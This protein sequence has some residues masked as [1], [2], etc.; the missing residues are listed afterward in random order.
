M[1]LSAQSI[2]EKVGISPWNERTKYMGMSYGL[3]PAGSDLRIR[4][5]VYLLTGKRECFTL[6]SVIEHIAMPNDVLGVIHDK[7]TWARLGLAVQNTVIEP[8]WQGYLTI[9]LTNHSD[10]QIVISEGMPICQ[11]I[12]H[13]L[14]QPTIQPYKG[15]YQDQEAGP[16]EA[17]FEYPK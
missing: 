13:Q 9:E 14:D 2:K 15:K 5:N 3:G 1:I 7:S 8:G 11:V 12:F 4:E 16:Q 6:A 17:R 10:R